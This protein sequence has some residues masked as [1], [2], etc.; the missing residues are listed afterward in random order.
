MKLGNFVKT[1]IDPYN[2]LEN[3][4]HEAFCQEYYRLDRVEKITWERKKRDDA[5]RKAYG[6]EFREDVSSRADRLIRTDRVRT[7]IR[8]LVEK[9]VDAEHE[10][11][12]WTKAK[13]EDFLID[14][15]ADTNTKDTAK[16]MAIKELNL[17]RKIGEDSSIGDKISDFLS[18]FNEKE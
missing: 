6:L 14:L 18:K 4:E 11:F 8:R 10:E 1:E 16:I 5:Y 17:L 3:E 12:K 9:G 13:A 7:R 2:P 15:I